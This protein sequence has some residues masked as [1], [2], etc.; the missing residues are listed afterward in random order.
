MEV[1]GDLLRLWGFL[2]LC[3]VVDLISFRSSKSAKAGSVSMI[4]LWRDF[5]VSKGRGGG[6][7]VAITC[8]EDLCGLVVGGFS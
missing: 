4:Y 1:W 7:E 8:L 6:G 5:W 2:L 3:C